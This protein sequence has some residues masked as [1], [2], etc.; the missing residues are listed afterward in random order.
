MTEVNDTPAATPGITGSDDVLRVRNL[1]KTFPGTRALDGVSLEVRR[2]EIHGLVGGNGSGKSTLIKILTGVYAGDSGG[3]VVLGE[4]SLSVEEVTPEIARA[5]GIR[6]VHQDLGVFLDLSVA[7]NLS[8]GSRYETQL[9]TRIRWGAVRR[10]AASLIERFEIDAAPGDPL[11]SLRQSS[12]TLVAIARACQDVGD[13]DDGVLILDEPTASL[14]AHEVD[15]LLEKLRG[16]AAG[17]RAILYVS[18]RLDEILDL[19]D[20][21]TALR[22][23]RV[24]G[25][26]MTRSLDEDRLV[27]LIAGPGLADVLPAPPPVVSRT[28]RLTVEGLQIGPVRGLSMTACRGEIVGIAGLLGSG[29]S[30]VLR[31]IFGVDPIR[32]GTVAIDGRAVRFNNVSEAMRAGV[33]YVPENRIE[34]AAFLDQPVYMNLAAA[35]TGSYYK[36]LRIRYPMMR[37]GGVELIEQFGIKTAGP[38]ALM[39]TLSGGNQQKVV[40]ARWVSRR[41][42]V[43]LLDEP[44]QGVDVGAR[45]EIWRIVKEVTAA[46]TSVV[47]VSSDFEELARVVDRAIVLRRGT[48][49][50]ELTGTALTADALTRLAYFDNKDDHHG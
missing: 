47:V 27:E 10:R 5:S 46:G 34:E 26:F 50:A 23:G 40:M 36:R 1:S 17:G 43:L 41:P 21:V 4:R 35:S 22:D 33:A 37:R 32:S 49:A 38:E 44:S 29:R 20:R 16:Y 42:R 13:T 31:G 39:S 24:A 11:R 8:L 9:N 15:L 48:V 45:A 28:P 2:G 14:P 18:H 6:V 25:T 30:S 19:T 7:E 3:Q 12:R